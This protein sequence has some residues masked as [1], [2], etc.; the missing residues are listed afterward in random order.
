M[1]DIVRSNLK[2]LRDDAQCLVMGSPTAEG[3]LLAST[4]QVLLLPAADPGGLGDDAMVHGAM[5]GVE[6]VLGDAALAVGAYHGE[7][8]GEFER[9][10]SREHFWHDWRSVNTATPT[11]VRYSDFMVLGADVIDGLY[12]F[13]DAIRRLRYARLAANL[14]L[15]TRLL[16]FSFNASPH[17]AVVRELAQDMTGITFCLRDPISLERFGQLCDAETRLVADVAFLVEPSGPSER[18]AA[19]KEFT[20]AQRQA[21]RRVVG[22]NIHPLFDMTH[23]SGAVASLARSLGELVRRQTDCA[24]VLIPHDYRPKFDDR[25][26]LRKIQEAAAAPDRVLLVSEP[27]FASQIKEICGYLDGVFTGRMHLAIA[28]LGQGVPIAG[29][30]YQGKFEGLLEHFELPQGLT[31]DPKRAADPDTV[32]AFFAQW[33]AR[34]ETLQTRVRERSPSVRQL[35]LDNFAN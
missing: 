26:A 17:P 1:L 32:V 6:R 18:T 16:G 29:I 20:D 13:T 28:A 21:G 9:R 4:R 35:A 10:P 15:R 34:I 19:V 12:S 33:L 11:F 23:G 14:G 7:G 24:F 8:A 5:V 3:S 31:I 25:V 27:L 22:L 2:R 30:V